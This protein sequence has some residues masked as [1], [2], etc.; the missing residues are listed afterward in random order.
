LVVTISGTVGLEAIFLGKRTVVLGEPFYR[1]FDPRMRAERIEDVDGVIRQALASP[2]PNASRVLAFATAIFEG[3][4]PVDLRR[5]YRMSRQGNLDGI[6]G[7][8]HLE[9]LAGLLASNLEAS[10]GQ[11]AH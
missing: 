11:A 4:V 2:E 6:M 5:L 10:V 1:V 9:R 8:E 3:S 7:D